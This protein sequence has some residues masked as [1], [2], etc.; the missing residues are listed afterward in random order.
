MP[1]AKVINSQKLP[2]APNLNA[3]MS[4]INLDTII[5]GAIERLVSRSNEAAIILEGQQVTA[6]MDSDIQVSDISH[7]LCLNMHVEI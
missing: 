5:I 7:Q 6:L 3:K 2:K 1:S 4:N